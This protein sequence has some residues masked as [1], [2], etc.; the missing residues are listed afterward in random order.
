MHVGAQKPEESV[1]STRPELQVDVRTWWQFQEPKP[2]HLLRAAST[3]L[4][5]IF[6]APR[7]VFKKIYF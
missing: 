7:L 2:G 3:L 6:P 5:L 4:K 1:G